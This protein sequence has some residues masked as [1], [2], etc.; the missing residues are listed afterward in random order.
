MKFVK[1]ITFLALLTLIFTSCEKDSLIT[2]VDNTPEVE[3]TEET[4]NS[5]V[6]AL[7]G[8]SLSCDEV[9]LATYIEDG[10]STVTNYSLSFSS[11]AL[12]TSAILALAWSPEQEETSLQEGDYTADISGLTFTAEGLDIIDA[13]IAAGSDPDAAPE[14]TEDHFIFYSSVSVVISTSNITDSEVNVVLSGEM[15]DP[16]GDTVD[17]SGSFVATLY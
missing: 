14:L 4:T 1:T 12:G 7:S 11:D 2:A 16:N 9:A 17:V 15:A 8:K 13:W 6:L 10:S 5:N 3:V